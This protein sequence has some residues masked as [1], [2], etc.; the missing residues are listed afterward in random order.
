MRALI[1]QWLVQD[2]SW[3]PVHV[4][5]RSL[6]D[7]INAPESGIVHLVHPSP[8]PWPT[9]AKALSS[10]LAVPL[11]PYHEW[12]SKLE[13]LALAQKEDTDTSLNAV[14]ALRL[15]NFYRSLGLKM[16][17]TVENSCEAFGLPRLSTENAVKASSTLADSEQLGGVDAK[18]WVSY[19]RAVGFM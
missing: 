18:L 8:T 3:L 12:L 19:W 11:V 7:I 1:S 16:D 13:H 15:L 9:L 6:V 2:V 4:A 10:E 5:G 17:G 14:A